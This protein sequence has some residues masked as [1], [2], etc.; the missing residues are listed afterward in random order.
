MN[1]QYCHHACTLLSPV[2]YDGGG[3][4]FYRFNCDQ[5]PVNIEYFK[6]PDGSILEM[7]FL[8]EQPG[9]RFRVFCNL[10]LKVCT[11]Q[12]QSKLESGWQYQ[13]VELNFLPEWDPHTIQDKVKNYSPFL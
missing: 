4:A 6:K 12:F 13:D 5:C 2:Y 11:L 1:C 8:W 7:R 3:L 9:K 10:E